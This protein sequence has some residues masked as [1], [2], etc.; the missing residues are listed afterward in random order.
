MTPKLISASYL[1]DYR[2][3]VRFADG[4]AGE[5]DLTHELWGEVFEPLRDV[6]KFREFEFDPE[7]GTIVWATG[8]DLAPEYLYREAARSAGA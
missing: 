8:A 5:I 3:S 7:L 6:A 4:T 2:I 1:R